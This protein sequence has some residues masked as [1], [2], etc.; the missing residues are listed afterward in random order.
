MLQWRPYSYENMICPWVFLHKSQIDFLSEY[1]TLRGKGV[2]VHPHLV[3]LGYN[4]I[5]WKS[6]RPGVG[7]A[8]LWKAQGA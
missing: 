5:L 7:W 3:K 4:S 8:S 6:G 1:A 2:L